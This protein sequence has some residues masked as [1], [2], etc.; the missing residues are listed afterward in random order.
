MRALH[1]PCVDGVP[2]AH[3]HTPGG[4]VVWPGGLPCIESC[5]AQLLGAAERL[6][7]LGLR[8]G[9]GLGSGLGLGLG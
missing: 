9:S 4:A 7:G 6:G 3:T 8:L 2:A 1:G 5:A